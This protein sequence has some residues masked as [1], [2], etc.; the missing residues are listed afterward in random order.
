MRRRGT[1]MHKLFSLSPIVIALA[2]WPA[3]ALP[4]ENPNDIL[5]V[6]NKKLE[7]NSVS[8][9]VLKEVFHKQKTAWTT[10][11]RATPIH[12]KDSKLKQQFIQKLFNHDIAGEEAFWQD[13]KIRS[14]STPPPELAN[15]LKAI[16]HLPGGVSY[17][18]RSQHVEG[19][20]K[21]L[22]VIPAQ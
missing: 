12:S 9:E 17:V 21:I 6:A 7:V 2:L 22:L 15:T 20:A 11:V 5:V 16:F 14:G 4:A 19:V 13:E 3:A 1:R 18:Y 10:G 8:I